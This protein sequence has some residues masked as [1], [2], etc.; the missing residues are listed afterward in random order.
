MKNLSRKDRA[1]DIPGKD[2]F[3][4]QCESVTVSAEQEAAGVVVVSQNVIPNR[5]MVFV[6]G[7]LNRGNYVLNAPTDGS[8]TFDIINEAD[9]ITIV[10]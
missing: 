9:E 6:N 8:I 7:A 1:N 5:A 10:F 2:S 3:Y 4:T